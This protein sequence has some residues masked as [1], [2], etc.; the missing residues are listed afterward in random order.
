MTAADR[1]RDGS[2]PLCERCGY[3]IEGLPIENACPECSRP[4]H[5]SLPE[6]RSGT[7]WQ[8]RRSLRTLLQ[9][10]WRT[11]RHPLRTFDTLRLDGIRLFGM[12]VPT[13]LLCSVVCWLIA[14]L[15]EIPTIEPLYRLLF[16]IVFYA[17]FALVFAVA[18]FMVS[19][20]VGLGLQI[21]SKILGTRLTPDIAWHIVG[22]ASVGWVLTYGIWL[23]A[24]SATELY[25]IIDPPQTDFELRQR[26]YFEDTYILFPAFFGG[27]GAGFFVFLGF[28][29]LGAYRLRYANPPAL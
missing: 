14:W 25:K 6:R 22:V 17:V 28:A 16:P 19:G 5:L 2:T 24:W 12:A 21:L 4:I 7:P 1:P 27:F 10:W 15:L 9:T 18:L 11:A 3:V 8:N 13:L 26:M 29:L 23:T 20:V